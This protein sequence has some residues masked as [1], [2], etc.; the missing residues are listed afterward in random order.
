MKVPNEDKLATLIRHR[1]TAVVNLTRTKDEAVA[2]RFVYIHIP[3]PD[4]KHVDFDVVE[5]G[6]QRAL[7]VV[8]TGGAILVHCNAGRNRSSL[9]NAIML[10][11]LYGM[12]GEQAIAW[13]R[14]YRA[15]ALA[16]PEFCEYLMKRE[17]RYAKN[18]LVGSR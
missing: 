18:S 2:H 7:N 8:R 13:M 12:T 3:I 10:M 4:S 9:F 16:T 1:I 11:E 6:I 15:N 14:A 5:R 17:V